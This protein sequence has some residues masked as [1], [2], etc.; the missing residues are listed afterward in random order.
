M[1]RNVAQTAFCGE[2]FTMKT[3]K[4]MEMKFESGKNFLHKR[5]GGIYETTVV[6]TL[7]RSRCLKN[8]AKYC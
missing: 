3:R 6:G 1:N 2:T 8:R 7:F 4:V 5:L